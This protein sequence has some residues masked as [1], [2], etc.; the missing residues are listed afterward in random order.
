MVRSWRAG[1]PHLVHV[2][3][4]RHHVLAVVHLPPVYKFH[5][6]D[7]LGRKVPVDLRY[8]KQTETNKQK[9]DDSDISGPEGNVTDSR[10]RQ[11]SNIHC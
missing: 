8:L 10:K 4:V 6:Q 5:G 2:Y 1:F 7:A 9:K 11:D 3:S